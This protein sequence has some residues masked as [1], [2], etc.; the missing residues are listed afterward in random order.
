MNLRWFLYNTISNLLK[1]RTVPSNEKKE[2][3]FIQQRTSGPLLNKIIV[4]K[5]RRYWETVQQF[6]SRI[7]SLSYL[8]M[9]RYIISLRGFTQIEPKTFFFFLLIVVYRIIIL[10]CIVLQITI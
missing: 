4:V 5:S 8:F 6:T 9:H 3:C 1:G 10:L 7:Y 2:L